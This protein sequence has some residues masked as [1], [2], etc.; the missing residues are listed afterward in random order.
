MVPVLA[1]MESGFLKLRSSR[2]KYVISIIEKRLLLMSCPEEHTDTN[3]DIKRLDELGSIKVTVQRVILQPRQRGT[4]CLGDGY[5]S[6]A[7]VSEKMLKGKAISNSV[8]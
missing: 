4:E 3:V 2:S 8:A 7:E 1:A 5:Q 6:V